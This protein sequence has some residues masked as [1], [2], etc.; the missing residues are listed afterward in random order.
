M[1]I[2][3]LLLVHHSLGLLIAVANATVTCMLVVEWEQ[4]KVMAHAGPVASVL[5]PWCALQVQR[6]QF[7]W[8]LL[9]LHPLPP[10]SLVLKIW[11]QALAI[12]VVS[13]LPLPLP[14]LPLS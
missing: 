5:L 10:P 2:Q 1:V 3:P 14:L 7:Q 13:M 12:L 11:L 8:S 9:P 6:P 4:K